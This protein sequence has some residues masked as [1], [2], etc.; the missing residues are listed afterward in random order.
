M[1][2]YTFSRDEFDKTIVLPVFNCIIAI[3]IV[4]CYFIIDNDFLRCLER[5]AD[6][7][8]KAGRFA[9]GFA[10]PKINR[11]DRGIIR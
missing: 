3:G 1:L 4:L 2:N 5:Q 7:Q 11:T 8:V 6:I 9:A 10:V